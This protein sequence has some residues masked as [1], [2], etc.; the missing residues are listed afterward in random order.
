MYA[1]AYEIQSSLRKKIFDKKLRNSFSFTWNKTS[2]NSKAT[3]NVFNLR[4]GS[5]YALKKKH[6]LNLN[7]AYTQNT[8]NENTTKYYTASLGYSFNFGWPKEKK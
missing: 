1:N 4:L 7:L 5:N 6:I 3:G 8:R 2:L